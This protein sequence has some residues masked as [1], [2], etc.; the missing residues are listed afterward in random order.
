MSAVGF[1]VIYSDFYLVNVWFSV[2][3]CVLKVA[4]FQ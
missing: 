3:F 4:E 1:C 2:W